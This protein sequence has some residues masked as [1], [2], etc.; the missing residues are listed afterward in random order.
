MVELGGTELLVSSTTVALSGSELVSSTMVVVTGVELMSSTM[1]VLSR[2]ELVSSTAV[3]VTGTELGSSTT[4]VGTAELLSSTA[5][6]VPSWA[7]LVNISTFDVSESSRA[8]EDS[9]TMTLVNDDDGPSG[10]GVLVAGSVEAVD[11]SGGLEANVLACLLMIKFWFCRL[12][13]GPRF[14]S[15][16]PELARL[17]YKAV[18]DCV[19]KSKSDRDIDV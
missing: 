7:E 12:T 11:V 18:A 14:A 10:E 19:D 2:S 4:V 5:A 3:V 1:V 9:T 8:V 16:D 15:G 6:V 17:L 13:A